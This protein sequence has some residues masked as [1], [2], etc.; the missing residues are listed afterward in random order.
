MQM[1]IKKWK[2]KRSAVEIEKR[3]NIMTENHEWINERSGQEIK[4]G[5]TRQRE[6]C[7]L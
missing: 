6:E 3:V 7:A 1:K 5:C 2:V 4:L